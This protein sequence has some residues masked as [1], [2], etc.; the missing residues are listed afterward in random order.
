MS[1]D[2]AGRYVSI[3]V[4][5]WNLFEAAGLKMPASAPGLYWR[6][7]TAP[8][9][10]RIPGVIRIGLAALAENLGWTTTQ[11]RRCAAELEGS[12]LLQADWAMRLV[13]LPALLREPC[14][15]PNSTSSAAVFG[16]ELADLPRC[17]LLDSID[18]ALRESLGSMSS[19]FLDSYSNCKRA[20]ESKADPP[21]ST[22]Q[23]AV[24][25]TQQPEGSLYSTL[26][27]PSL[28]FP[29]PA[30]LKPDPKPK[31]LAL[32][33]PKKPGRPKASQAEVREVVK[34]FEDRWVALMR[35]EDG[36]KPAVNSADWGQ[37]S[38]L[39]GT[40]GVETAKRLV[41]RFLEDRDPFLMKQGHQLKHL[42]SRANAYRARPVSGKTYEVP[43]E[44]DGEAYARSLKDGG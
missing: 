33:E 9:G 19:A 32:K 28:P 10:T 13:V 17:E 20:G 25:A 27:Y 29:G 31:Q 30:P 4:R 43:A 39:I 36:K 15:R 2:S 35:P 21:L 37:T 16:R 11:V 7:A 44:L 12:G 26:L 23:A 22:G 8:E 6:L 5:S 14:S 41:D 3:P 1:K 42:P 40:F 24:G 34:H 38:S 18:Q